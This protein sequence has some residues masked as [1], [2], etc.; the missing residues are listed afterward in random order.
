MNTLISHLVNSSNL[1]RSPAICVISFSFWKVGLSIHSCYIAVIGRA[2]F[3]R[4]SRMS[5]F[6]RWQNVELILKTLV[7]DDIFILQN[8]N[9]GVLFCGGL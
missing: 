9:S 2:M 4:S 6:D 7:L 1:H 8:N 5:L 3:S